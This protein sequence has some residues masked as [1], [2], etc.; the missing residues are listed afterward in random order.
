MTKKNNTD[1]AAEDT[2]TALENITGA[3]NTKS[4]KNT[5]NTESAK[6]TKG[7]PTTTEST[8]Q[9]DDYR[10]NARFTALQGKYLRERA[11]NLRKSVTAAL[12]III[13]EDMQ[14]HPEIK[15]TIDELNG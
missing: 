13:E 2:K 1:F 11:W 14:R 7:R 6:N 5:K 12:Q 4:T 9:P 8:P 3:S 10:F 15:K